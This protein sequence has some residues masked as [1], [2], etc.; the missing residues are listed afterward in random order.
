MLLDMSK[1]EDKLHG[2]EGKAQKRSAAES[3][4]CSKNG[5]HLVTPGLHNCL[6]LCLL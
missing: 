3:Y 1:A 4:Y 5:K 6:N 2:E